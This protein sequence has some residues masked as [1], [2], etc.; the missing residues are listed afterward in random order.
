[1]TKKVG[2][3]PLLL[4]GSSTRPSQ[5][6]SWPS[7]TSGATLVV[8]FTALHFEALPPLQMKVPKVRQAPS[9]GAGRPTSLAQG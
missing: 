5:S 1:L 9:P 8:S 3:E 6:L 7:Q 2:L 4:K